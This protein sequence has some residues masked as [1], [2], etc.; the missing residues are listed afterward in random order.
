MPTRKTE[1]ALGIPS[2]CTLGD[3]VTFSCSVRRRRHRQLI[4]RILHIW[5][6]KSRLRHWQLISRI[7]HIWHMKSR[8]RYQPLIEDPAHLEIRRPQHPEQ[9]EPP[10][11]WESVV[12]LFVP[13]RV[14]EGI[15][16]MSYQDQ[17]LFPPNSCTSDAISTQ[18]SCM[19]SGQW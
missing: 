9:P 14:Q 1:S 13:L 15:R 19:L 12:Y 8:L 4:F 17:R 2:S 11:F 6:M 16:H 7:L 3:T 10:M 18:A 5:H